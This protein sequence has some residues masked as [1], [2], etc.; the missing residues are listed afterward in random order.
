MYMRIYNDQLIKVYS[1][2]DLKNSDVI[3][4]LKGRDPAGFTI[5]DEENNIIFQEIEEISSKELQLI[6]R[7]STKVTIAIKLREDE[8]IEYFYNVAKSAFST[9]DRKSCTPEELYEWMNA[10]I[11]AGIM[12]S[13][14]WDETE[15]KI[16]EKLLHEGFIVGLDSADKIAKYN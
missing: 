4:K 3:G 11:D 6:I 8:V 12:R 1:A 2:E 7:N 14:V 9:H 15:P 5:R 10:S 16:L 13:D